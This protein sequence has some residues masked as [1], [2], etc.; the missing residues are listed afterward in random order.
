M[1]TPAALGLNESTVREARA[2]CPAPDT[3]VGLDLS[4]EQI[5]AGIVALYVFADG[6]CELNLAPQANLAACSHC[7]KTFRR[8]WK[9]QQYCDILCEPDRSAAA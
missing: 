3:V 1:S 7:G 5:A 4:L 6:T 9:A 2:G 8:R